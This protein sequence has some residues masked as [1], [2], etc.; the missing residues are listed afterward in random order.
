MHALGSCYRCASPIALIW[1]IIDMDFRAAI[2]I[3][4]YLT[5]AGASV[6]Y[7]LYLSMSLVMKY[8]NGLRVLLQCNYSESLD[9]PVSSK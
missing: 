9:D 7:F 5:K 4:V 3:A 6:V 2:G 8:R 1:G